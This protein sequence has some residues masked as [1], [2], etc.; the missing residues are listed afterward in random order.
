MRCSVFKKI[1][2]KLLALLSSF[3]VG[4]GFYFLLDAGGIDIDGGFSINRTLVFA[5]AAA[6]AFLFL[7]NRPFLIVPND[8]M[9][10]TLLIADEA[11]LFRIPRNTTRLVDMGDSHLKE[12]FLFD[13]KMPDCFGRAN[14]SAIIAKLFA[15][16]D[17]GDEPRGVKARQACFQEG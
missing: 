4:F 17:T 10:G 12:T 9:I 14:S 15:I 13:G 16:T 2:A 5:D 1:E 8:R 11:Y 7:H 3:V 6:R